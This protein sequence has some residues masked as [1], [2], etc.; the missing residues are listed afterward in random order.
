M[1]RAIGI[2]YGGKRCGLAVTDPLR[3]AVNPLASVPTSELEQYLKHYL[4]HERVDLIVLVDPVHKD[5]QP[6][7]LGPAIHT[8]GDHLKQ[9]YPAIRIDYIDEKN[10]SVQA[11]HRLVRNGTPRNKRNKEAIDQMSAILILQ[12]YLNHI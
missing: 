10:S 12:K 9:I 1:A 2:D 4:S 11:V 3:I 7:A 5:G 6:T 8:F